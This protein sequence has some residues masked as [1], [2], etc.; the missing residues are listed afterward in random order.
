LLTVTACSIDDDTPVNQFDQIVIED[1]S[2]KLE[3]ISFLLSIK[4]SNGYLN[5]NQINDLEIFANTEKWGVF[6]SEINNSQSESDVIVNNVRYSDSKINYLFVAKSELLV[7]D[8]NL[9]TTG[10]F[11][12]LLNSRVVLTPGNYVSELIGLSYENEI[13]EV[14]TKDIQVFRELE[15]KENT[16]SSFLGEIEITIED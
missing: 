3:Q 5:V 15:V 11:I 2:F 4:N 7:S 10:D 16:T 6:S 9:S 14:I 1:D 8:E 13:A 12:N